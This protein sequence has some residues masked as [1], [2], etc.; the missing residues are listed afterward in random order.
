MAEAYTE[1]GDFKRAAEI[2]TKLLKAR[3]DN[4]QVLDRLWRMYV[5]SDQKD[6]AIATLEELAKLDRLRFEIYNTLGELYEET[7]KTEAAIANYQ[8]SLV[9]N[10]NQLDK[11]MR[12]AL[13]Q[14][15]TKT[16]DDAS[17][18]LLTAKEKFPTKYQ[19]PYL[20]G[21]L[22]TD[23]K[24]YT[25]ALASFAD[26]EA[27]A[28]VD[29]EEIKPG[30]AFYFAYGSA[31][32]RAG[33]PEKAATLFRKAIDLDPNNHNAYNYLGYM[34]ADK[35]VHLEES[36]ELIQ[37]ALKLDPDNGAY[38][39]SLGWVLFRLGRYEEALPHLRRA[40]ENLQKEERQED[41]TVL[42]HLAEVLIKLGKRDEAVDAW[43][44]ALKVDPANKDVGEKLQKYSS[45]H[46][47]TH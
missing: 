36:L 21:L 27:L 43:Q 11:Y 28:K 34:W 5:R 33:D 42:D 38:L 16:F 25:N 18:T 39:D 45:D 6:K 23:Q 31:C 40:V 12:I 13:A 41:A 7:D 15:K 19:I 3:P 29:P 32:E 20:V 1:S 22:Q 24:N 14:M 30:S 47:A 8:Q 37:R 26:A 46:T 9:L 10:P 35:G 2:Y 17:M 44:R 4:Q